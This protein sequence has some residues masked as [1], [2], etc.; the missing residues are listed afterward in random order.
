MPLGGSL[1]FTLYVAQRIL[2]D[3]P[4]PQLV[5]SLDCL[6]IGPATL[7]IEQPFAQEPGPRESGEVGI[8]V[9]VVRNRFRC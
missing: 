4:G 7:A 3:Q 5:D 6:T 8:G 1:S 2:P 9:L